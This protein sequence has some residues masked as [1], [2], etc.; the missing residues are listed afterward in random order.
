MNKSQTAVVT[1]FAPS[2]SGRLH[3]GHAL[4][5]IIP[6]RE[7]QQTGGRF[8]LRIEDIDFERCHKK[9]ETGIFED[10]AW[11]GLDW[12]QP[13]RRQSEHMDDYAR[14]LTRL[15]EMGVIYPCFC[16][17]AEI[18]AEVARSDSAPHGP[19]TGPAMGPDGA[20]YPGTCRHLSV[21]EREAR[22]AAGDAHALRL[23]MT[24]ALAQITSPLIWHD[25]E[26]GE[27]TANPAAFGDVVLA[28]K[29]TPTSYHLSVVVDDA[30]QGITLVTRG[31]DL[32]EATDIHRLLQ[33]LLDL[34]TPD[35]FHHRLVTGDDGRR[36]ATRHKARTLEDIRNSGL[37]AADLLR[38][39]E[40]E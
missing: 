39:L 10:L 26:A 11:L 2:P 1:R 16:S 12:E 6:W 3:P 14:A 24:A 13:V 33:A 18:R 17:R 5:A 21:D 9:F 4:A 30:I 38:Q 15:D 19:A 35:Y 29:D 40:L 25:R 32:L 7:A 27:R 36:L 20:L 22:L 31:Q 23:D 37:A 34:P 28:R 8:L